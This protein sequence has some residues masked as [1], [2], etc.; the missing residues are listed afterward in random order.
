[1]TEP[2]L[3]DGVFVNN[4]TVNDLVV[5]DPKKPW[6]MIGAFL[7]PLVLMLINFFT[8]NSDG[9]TTITGSEWTTLATTCVLTAAATF[10]L[11]NPK[12]LKA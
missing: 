4:T 11:S 2:N 7:T 6:K 5:D 3:G 10:G 1:M 12:T 9:G 8:E